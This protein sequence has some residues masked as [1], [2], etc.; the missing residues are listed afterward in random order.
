MQSRLARVTVVAVAGALAAGCAASA[1]QRPLPT[2]RIEKGPETVESARR[3]LEGRWTLLSLDVAA[4]DGR[5]ASVQATGVL[6]A[7]AFGN[8]EV[9]YRLS[10]PGRKSLEAIGV[11]QANPVISTTG[12]VAIDTQA[13]TITYVAP[14]TSAKPFDAGLAARRADPFALERVRVLLARRRR[15]P[16]A[17]HA[18]RQRPERRDQPLAEGHIRT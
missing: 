13:H 8:M 10:E 7:D 18:P 9:E 6:T 16:H 15:R 11:S 1:R 5:S 3:V 4:E 14:G 12:R 2:S 17:V